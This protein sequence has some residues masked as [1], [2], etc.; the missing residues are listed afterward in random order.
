MH[1]KCAHMGEI[2]HCTLRSRLMDNVHNVEDNRYESD[3]VI[4][5]GSPKWVFVWRCYFT[6]EHEIHWMI[7]NITSGHTA[8]WCQLSKIRQ[9]ATVLTWNDRKNVTFWKSI[10]NSPCPRK[11]TKLKTVKSAYKNKYYFGPP[12]PFPGKILWVIISGL[13]CVLLGIYAA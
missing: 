8:A 9:T 7:R 12:Q 1:G 11:S 6:R 2:L 3:A 10:H 13:T 4:S 5:K